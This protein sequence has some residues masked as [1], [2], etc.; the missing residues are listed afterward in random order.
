MPKVIIRAKWNE[1]LYEKILNIPAL[2]NKDVII[3]SGIYAQGQNE[4]IEIRP[5]IRTIV[6]KL[7][8][9]EYVILIDLQKWITETESFLSEKISLT[10]SDI[11]NAKWN[12]IK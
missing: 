7:D 10:E 2:P 3:F 5:E 12:R 9:I 4:K 8:P 11:T 1:Y 6:L